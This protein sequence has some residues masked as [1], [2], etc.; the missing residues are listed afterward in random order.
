M[1][2]RYSLVA[3]RA[4]GRCEYCRAP[5]ESFNLPF[6]VE[7]IVPLSQE[8][9]NSEANLALSCR[10]C[11]LFKGVAV[12]AI[13]PRSEIECRLFNRRIDLWTEHL[14][15][16]MTEGTISGLTAIGRATVAQ[17]RLNSPSQIAARIKWINSDLYP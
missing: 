8:G 9:N 17:L 13:D 7:H 2:S 14:E 10:S 11:N 12:S 16:H 5:E 1:S 15:I 3:N 4:G 6:E